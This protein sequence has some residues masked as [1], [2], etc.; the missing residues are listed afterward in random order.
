MSLD[1]N[2]LSRALRDL[3][4]EP[5]TPPALAREVAAAHRRRGRRLTVAGAVASVAAV[6]A[7]AFAV[8]A[9]SRRS[10]PPTS[11]PS[12]PL[13]GGNGVV[14]VQ[15]GQPVRFCVAHAKDDSMRH[16]DLPPSCGHTVTVSGLDL[17][18]LVEPTDYPDGRWA[19]MWLAGVYRDGTL[20]VAR[21]EAP[22]A[23]VD[24]FATNVP[25]PEPPGGWPVNPTQVVYQEPGPNTF[26]YVAP[27]NAALLQ[28]S[29]LHPGVV[30]AHRM[31]Y[32]DAVLPDREPGPRQ[33]VLVVVALDADLVRDALRPT[34][35]DSL[36]VVESE[37]TP[38]QVAAAM[39]DARQ[40]TVPRQSAG[41]WN[42]GADGQ[43]FVPA[44][45]AIEDEAAR[46]LV[47]RHP[48]GLVHLS[49]WLRPVS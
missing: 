49:A 45:V 30:V 16:R 35:G 42:I 17:D 36:C 31:G 22:H 41:D 40:F 26:G 38:A 11:V 20:H 46:A 33:G 18:R 12:G 7:V 13:V 28:W 2:A 47:A 4:R 29:Q 24:D 6:A 34:Y 10:A 44:F 8:P 39:E 37:Y 14:L 23:R 19:E 48:A 25:C 43:V 15:P 5:A 3:V 32:G 27:D 1:E 9:A 21:Q